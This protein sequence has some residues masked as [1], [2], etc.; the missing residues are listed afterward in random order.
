[1]PILPFLHQPIELWLKHLL[2]R[3]EVV[4][5]IEKQSESWGN[6]RADMADIFDGEGLRNLRAADGSQFLSKKAGQLQLVFTLNID[7]FNPFGQS[8]KAISIGAIYLV[9]HNLPFHMWYRTENVYLAGI[10][11][12]PSEPNF[13]QINHF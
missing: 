9:C 4:S 12:G 11:P 13:D 5:E 3:P 2:S 10:I 7:W 6:G 8:H 1:V